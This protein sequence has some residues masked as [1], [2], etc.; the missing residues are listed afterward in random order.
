MMK[1]LSLGGILF[2]LPCTAIRKSLDAH[3]TWK[4]EIEVPAGSIFR[5]DGILYDCCVVSF[6]CGLEHN[7]V[8]VSAGEIFEGVILGWVNI[9]FD[10]R[11]GVID[12]L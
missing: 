10:V 9:Y 6:S 5:N 2:E 1:Y 12:H 11:L 4:M 3:S 8:N 7:E